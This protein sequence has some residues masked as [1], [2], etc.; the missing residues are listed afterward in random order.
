MSTQFSR[1][2]NP[3]TVIV[4]RFGLRI[5]FS[6]GFEASIPSLRAKETAADCVFACH[7][8]ST[9]VCETALLCWCATRGGGSRAPCARVQ[10]RLGRAGSAPHTHTGSQSPRVMRAHQAPLGSV[11]QSVLQSA[12]AAGGGVGHGYRKRRAG[13]TITRRSVPRRAARCCAGYCA[14]ASTAPGG[15]LRRV[16]PASGHRSQLAATPKRGADANGRGVPTS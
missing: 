14:R 9:K 12:H 2:S 6:A 5:H 13:A 1:L 7:L 10:R 3:R 16:D 15:V 11:L 8:T 4:A